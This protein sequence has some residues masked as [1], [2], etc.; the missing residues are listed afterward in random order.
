MF[1][2]NDYCPI[3]HIDDKVTI[4]TRY[5]GGENRYTFTKIIKVNKTTYK[6][7]SGSLFHKDTLYLRG[8]SKMCYTPRNFLTKTT[9]EQKQQVVKL[10]HIYFLDHYNFKKLPFET[11]DEIIKLIKTYESKKKNEE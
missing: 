1:T 3:F 9:E 11:L 10:K 2:E 8:V 5:Y 4:V 6:V 7:E